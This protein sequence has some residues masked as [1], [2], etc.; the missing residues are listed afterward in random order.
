M[1]S[2]PEYDR[3]RQIEYRAQ[4]SIDL[5]TVQAVLEYRGALRALH[6]LERVDLEH[7]SPARSGD[8]YAAL[9]AAKRRVRS[10]LRD[11][12]LMLTEDA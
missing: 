10:T 12:D 3:R 7:M 1:A 9:A 8:H 11:L 6:D 2:S 5:A 4:E